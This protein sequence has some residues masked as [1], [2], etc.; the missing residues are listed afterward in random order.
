MQEKVL[1]HLWLLIRKTHQWVSTCLHFRDNLNMFSTDQDS[2]SSE[3]N[4]PV[5]RLLS[6]QRPI[7]SSAVFLPVTVFLLSL[8]FCSV[9]SVSS[10][11]LFSA[12]SMCTWWWR[13]C[14]SYPIIL[15]QILWKLSGSWSSTYHRRVWRVSSTLLFL[16]LKPHWQGSNQFYSFLV[17]LIL[18]TAWWLCTCCQP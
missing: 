15:N 14:R 18:P 9:L 3:V 1:Y 11:H 12:E 2:S 10:L 7:L 5:L 6:W 4:P 16:W 17:Q 8:Q 13:C